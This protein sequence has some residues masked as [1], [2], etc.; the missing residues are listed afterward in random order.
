M[1]AHCERS[2]QRRDISDVHPM[3]APKSTH[4]LNLHM[5]CIL[6][7]FSLNGITHVDAPS[8]L[9]FLSYYSKVEH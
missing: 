1:W 3:I 7:S 8:G 5:K 4:I 9:C 2:A 6:S